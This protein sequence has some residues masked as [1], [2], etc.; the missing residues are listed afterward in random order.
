MNSK[1]RQLT[2][3]QYDLLENIDQV[4]FKGIGQINTENNLEIYYQETDN[5][6]VR[7]RLNESDG[8]LMRKGDVLTQMNFDLN[9]IQECKVSTSV[10]DIYMDV[11]TINIELE[12]NKV[13]LYYELSEAGAVVGKFELRLEWENE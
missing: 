1:N 3:R 8:F 2:V 11:N 10:G 7:L 13:F 12:K 6:R 9:A 4:I 5:T